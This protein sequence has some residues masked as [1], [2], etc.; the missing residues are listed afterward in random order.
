MMREKPVNYCTSSGALPQLCSSISVLSDVKDD[1]S[2]QESEVK[3]PN[4]KFRRIKQGWHSNITKPTST[5]QLYSSAVLFICSIYVYFIHDYHRIY[6][7]I[8]ASH[9]SLMCVLGPTLLSL[10]IITILKCYNV[11]PRVLNKITYEIN[12]F[13]LLLDISNELQVCVS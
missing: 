11:L 8:L 13:F 1:L 2:I 7:F 10:I 4:S 5:V 6:Q 9:S 3:S 12:L